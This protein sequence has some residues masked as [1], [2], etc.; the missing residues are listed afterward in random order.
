MTVCIHI[1]YIY[2]H[3]LAILRIDIQEKLEQDL[4][5][6]SLGLKLDRLVSFLPQRKKGC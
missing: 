2:I 6:W 3:Y 4:L 1:I 5:V